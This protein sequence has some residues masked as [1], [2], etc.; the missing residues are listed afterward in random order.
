MKFIFNEILNTDISTPKR[1]EIITAIIENIE[2]VI[3]NEISKKEI[4]NAVKSNKKCK[5]GAGEFR[6]FNLCNG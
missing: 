2:T 1:E 3:T 6:C 4:E 5:S